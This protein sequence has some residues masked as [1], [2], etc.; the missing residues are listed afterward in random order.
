M[1]F[2]VYSDLHITVNKEVPDIKPETDY[3]ILA[4]DIG[5]YHDKNFIEFIKYV[6]SNWKKVFYILGNHEA[7]SDKYTFKELL[8]M[9]EKLFSKY[10][11]IVFLYNKTYELD[12][13]LIVG[14]TLWSNP[15]QIPSFRRPI[16][17]DINGFQL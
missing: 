1:E 5:K 16:L 17:F 4:G 3:L 12:D 14:T 7:Y 8:G 13:Y 11:N 6:N 10:K 9:F 2:Q 15:Y